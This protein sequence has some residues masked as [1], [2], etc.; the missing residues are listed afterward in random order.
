[1]PTIPI[2][3][4]P[5]VIF[6]LAYIVWPRTFITYG[7]QSQ[8]A[9]RSRWSAVSDW[10]AA[11]TSSTSRKNG[12]VRAVSYGCGGSGRNWLAV[13]ST[14]GR[15]IPQLGSTASMYA[16]GVGTQ[17]PGVDVTLYFG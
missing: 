7:L 14:K 15:I 5:G 13:S 6:L 16:G 17:R 4:P 2:Q 9:V 11:Y 8:N 12:L 1:M 3:C 10:R